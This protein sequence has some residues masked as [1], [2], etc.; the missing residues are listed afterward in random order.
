M[1]QVLDFFR[2]LFDTSDW[3]ARW[4]SGN[5]SNF[6]GWLYIISDL[7]IWSAFV[8]IPMAIFRY[9]S[10]R[11]DSRFIRTYVL[12]AILILACGL[13]HLLNAV[14]FWSPLYRLDALIR[15]MT[16]LL[17]WAVV[18]HLIQF[19]PVASSLR[20]HADLEKD[21]TER[22]KVEQ[23]LQLTNDQL[24][25]A[26][27]IARL[28]HWEWD[29]PNNRVTWSKGLHK[30]YETDES[31][32]LSYEKYLEH[33]H[34][35]DRDFVH[36]TIQQAYL[37]KTFPDFTHRIR[38]SGE[39]EKIIYSK[40][41]VVTN[42]AGE[43]LKMIGTAQDITEQ[44]KTQQQ[45]MERTLELENMNAELQKFAYVA[46]HDLQ[47]PLRKIVTFSSLLEKEMQSNLSDRSKMYM[48]KIVQSSQRMQMLIDD[49]L[50]FSSLTA[51][52][53]DYKR[54][55]LNIVVKQV[56]S[57]MEIKLQ[58]T[59]AVIK[60]GKL[61]VMDA[62]ASQM[63]QLFQNLLTNALKFRQENSAPEITIS[64]SIVDA[65]ELTNYHWFDNQPA[66]SAGYSYS[67]GREQFAKITVSD[68]GIGFDESHAEKIFEIFQRLHTSHLY[69]GTGI[70]LAICKKIVDNH[71]GII[72]AEGKI[73][74]G[75]TFTIILPLS[76]KNFF[77]E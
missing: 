15:L 45:M 37:T 7:L 23:D 51:K 3:P 33:L 18:W 32:E 49:I 28:G 66:S 29:V 58:E 55:D 10:R 43:V 52:K 21:V 38:T 17:A 16:G 56:L 6:H 34:P 13:V 77:S 59:G 64:H 60:V 75:A 47:E 24:N 67:W 20:T 76:Q 36:N 12:F 61:P 25:I 42:D 50:Q 9:V 2:T 26:Q 62:I 22:K 8:V 5:W 31:I 4:S 74:Q 73:N 14:S 35:E 65:D 40:G 41:E 70:G 63:M 53:S 1:E 72:S 46:S 11:P 48:D 27:E 68:N 39:K 69:E 19:M 57:D 54:T 44:Q 30:I 71:H